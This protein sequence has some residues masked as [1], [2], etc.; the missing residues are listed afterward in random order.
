MNVATI[1][2]YITVIITHQS[3]IT[4]THCRKS[5]CLFQNSK[6][7]FIFTSCLIRASDYPH[8]RFRIASGS[9]QILVRSDLT[10]ILQFMIERVDGVFGNVRV[11]FQLIYSRNFPVSLDG[12]VLVQNGE[13]SVSTSIP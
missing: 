3:L 11:N 8:G 2:P 13:R 12:F 5:Y 6:V 9:E 4:E 1:M 7:N 10:R